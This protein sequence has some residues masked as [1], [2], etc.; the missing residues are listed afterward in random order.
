M[1]LSIQVHSMHY[2]EMDVVACLWLNL[3]NYGCIIS[4][5]TVCVFPS[6]SISFPSPST[7]LLTHYL[8]QSC[9]HANVPPSSFPLHITSSALSGFGPHPFPYLSLS[10]CASLSI[11]SGHN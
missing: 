7:Y 11:P 4:V 5:Y 2:V 8:T 10:V 1:C 6:L 9:S 3:P